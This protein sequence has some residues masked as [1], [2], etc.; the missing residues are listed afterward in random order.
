MAITIVPNSELLADDSIPKATLA[1][2]EWPMPKLTL[3]Q[4]NVAVPI[5]MSDQTTYT[6]E[7]MTNLGSVVFMTL[8]RGHPKLKREEFN[9]WPITFVEL[10]DA[11]KVVSQQAVMRSNKAVNGVAAGPLE[12]SATISAT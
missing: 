5:L 1:G 2:Q 3:E 4:L 9:Q 11:V 10:L 6:P 7:R 12:T 8:L